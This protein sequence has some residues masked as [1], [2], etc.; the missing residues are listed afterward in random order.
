M[1]LLSFCSD[2]ENRCRGSRW[3]LIRRDRSPA[4]LRDTA[5][6]HKSGKLCWSTVCVQNRALFPTDPLILMC[7]STVAF[8]RISLSTLMSSD[9]SLHPPHLTEVISCPDSL[10]P[11]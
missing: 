10:F 3:S 4:S 6:L 5:L 9:P 1:E 2:V 7:G 11:G 8:S